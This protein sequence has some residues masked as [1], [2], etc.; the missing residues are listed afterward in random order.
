MSVGLSLYVTTNKIS[1]LVQ[2][3]I[4]LSS[5]LSGVFGRIEIG[6]VIVIRFRRNLDK[7]AL[8]VMLKE[9]RNCGV[10]IPDAGNLVL[11]HGNWVATFEK[12]LARSV[13]RKLS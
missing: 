2:R 8:R 13:D 12:I 9:E 11:A 10:A 3:D 5:L 1:S 6:C 4:H 7:G